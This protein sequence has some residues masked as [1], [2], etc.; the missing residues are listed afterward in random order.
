MFSIVFIKLLPKKCPFRTFFDETMDENY[1]ISPGPTLMPLALGGVFGTAW[2]CFSPKIT[3]EFPSG[4][5]T[6]KR[7]ITIFK[8][9]T[10]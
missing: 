9:Y 3:G 10:I 1:Q 4:K 2:H 6:C 7:N 5:L 8:R